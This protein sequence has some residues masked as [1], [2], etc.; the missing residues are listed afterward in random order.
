VSSSWSY[1][2]AAVLPL[3]VG[4]SVLDVG[5]GMGRWGA[6]IETNYWE[7]KLE[8]APA[9]DGIDLFDA[10]IEHCQARGAYRRVWKHTVP[11]P[12]EGQWDTVLASEI[13]EH[14]PQEQVEEAVT[15]LEEAARR[16]VIFTTPNGP[17]YRPGHETPL[18]FNP[19]EAHVS[20]LR[21]SFFAERGYV[22]RGVGFG[23]YAGRLAPLA[24]RLKLRKSLMS[25]TWRLP[26][27]SE[28]LVA[29][30]DTGPTAS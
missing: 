5:C 30:K 9:V 3:I 26:R 19:Y 6:L 21:P 29:Y 28:T 27:L 2:D 16:R 14:L 11:E 12:L 4:E 13:L 7:A 20:E 24:K 10:N 25:S 8:T 22:V 18:G 23:S 17:A 1:L 15:R